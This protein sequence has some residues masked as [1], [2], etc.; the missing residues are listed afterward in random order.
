MDDEQWRKVFKR[1]PYQ[2]RRAQ[3]PETPFQQLALPMVGLAVAPLFAILLAI[4]V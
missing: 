1:P 2:R 3:P 4:G